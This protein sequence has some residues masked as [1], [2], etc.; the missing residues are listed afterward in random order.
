MM[1]NISKEFVAWRVFFILIIY[2]YV[3]G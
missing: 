2:R 1:V 3:P